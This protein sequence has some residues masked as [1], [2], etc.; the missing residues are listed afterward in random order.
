MPPLVGIA[1]E[2]GREA[3][4]GF[5]RDDGLNP[6]LCQR[7]AQPVRVESPVREKFSAAQPFYERRRAAQ[8]VGLSGQQAASRSG[9]RARLSTP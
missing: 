5:G 9:C 3:A 2:F 8:V 6:G 7:L 1:V 4:V